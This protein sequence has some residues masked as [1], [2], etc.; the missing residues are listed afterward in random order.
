MLRDRR[1]YSSTLWALFIGAIFVPMLALTFDVGRYMYARQELGKAADAAAVAAV[2][3]IN[4]RVF[5]ENGGI[6]LTGATYGMAQS[7]ADMNNDYLGQ[8]NIHPAVTSIQINQGQDTVLVAVS[9]DLT[10]LFPS[11][12]PQILVTETGT[13]QVQGR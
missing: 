5:R 2:T 13:A 3:E 10:A 9:A 11:I 1:A 8:F 12:T 4:Q 6:E 7:Y